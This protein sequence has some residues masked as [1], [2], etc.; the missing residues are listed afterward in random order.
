MPLV[1]VILPTCDRPALWPRALDSVLRQTCADLEVLL[2]DSNRAA[3]PVRAQPE[4]AARRA[5]ARVVLVQGAHRPNASAARNLGLAAARGEWITYLDD[6]DVYHPEKLARQRAAASAATASFVLCGYGVNLPRRRRERQVSATLFSGDELLT[7]AHWGTPMLFHRADAAA[8]FDETLHAGHDEVFAHAFLARHG[9]NAVPNCA[10]PLVEVYPQIGGS[11]V[12]ADGE[13]I[14]EAYRRNWPVA[15]R[16]FS[17]R[18]CRG[19]VAMGRLVRAQYGHGDLRHFG[20]CCGAVL[21]TRG[22]G[23]WRLV[24]NA[25]ARRFGLFS[26]WIVS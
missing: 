15:R 5:D 16:R 2:V 21:R 1:S 14:W 19:Y 12:H 24:A 18:A 7:A 10:R 26:R 25:T 17:R 8:R 3:P 22:L 9:V 4:F 6:D 13:G 11:R 20:R 23:A